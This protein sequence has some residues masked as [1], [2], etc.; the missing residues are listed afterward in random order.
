MSRNEDQ[1][2]YIFLPVTVLEWV[3]QRMVQQHHHHH[4]YTATTDSIPAMS[5]IHG[6]SSR[7]K[8][9]VRLACRSQPPLRTD[10]HMYFSDCEHRYGVIKTRWWDLSNIPMIS[11]PRNPQML[12]HILNGRS[13]II[14]CWII[15]SMAQKG[16]WL[17]VRMNE[18]RM[19][20]RWSQSLALNFNLYFTPWINRPGGIC[21]T[22]PICRYH[23]AH[24]SALSVWSW[25]G[26]MRWIPAIYVL[27]STS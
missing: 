19:E 15:A 9:A 5:P 25:N 23:T 16:N 21:D 13:Y 6:R 10:L 20:I 12:Y 1:R 4:Y 8:P 18:S 11:P 22:Y 14:A 3:R 24:G 27:H 7:P 2:I 17:S 26:K